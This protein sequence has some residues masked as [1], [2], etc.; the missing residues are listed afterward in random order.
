MLKKTGTQNVLQRYRVQNL[1]ING[2]VSF[3]KDISI[4]MR[5]MRGTIQFTLA[6]MLSDSDRI[7]QGFS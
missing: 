3:L 7:D 2:R 4:I 5:M 6:S 1:S